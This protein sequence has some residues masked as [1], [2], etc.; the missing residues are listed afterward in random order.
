MSLENLASIIVVLA[1]LQIAVIFGYAHAY[2][3][4][5]KTGST[6]RELLLI[7]P[8][9]LP[10]FLLVLWM[11][12]FFDYGLRFGLAQAFFWTWGQ[13]VLAALVLILGRGFAR[14]LRT[15]YIAKAKQ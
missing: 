10:S 14:W 7:V 11:V 9:V 1:L 12:A 13:P 8:L 6:T 3:E 2:R 4:S 15:R 5:L